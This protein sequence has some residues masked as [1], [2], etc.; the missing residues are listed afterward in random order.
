MPELDDIVVA[1]ETPRNGDRFKNLKVCFKSTEGLITM[2]DLLHGSKLGLDACL[3]GDL[4]KV[5][6]SIYIGRGRSIE[7][8]TNPLI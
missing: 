1:W 7:M 8:Q 4:R 2:R 3:P 6:K 5:S